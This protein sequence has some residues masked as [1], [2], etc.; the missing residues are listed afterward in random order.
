MRELFDRLSSHHI[1]A[2]ATPETL[3]HAASDEPD[4]SPHPFDI[5][6][7]EALYQNIIP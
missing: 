6:A 2:G 1:E 5:M 3:N 7:I 4:C